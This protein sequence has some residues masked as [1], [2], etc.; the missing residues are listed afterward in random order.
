MI[1]LMPQS[2]WAAWSVQPRRR[3]RWVRG[4]DQGVAVLG[5]CEGDWD[6]RSMGLVEVEDRDSRDCWSVMD[7][8]SVEIFLCVNVVCEG[9]D[10]KEE[11]S[12]V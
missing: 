7:S 3:A 2:C 1:V 12:R 11:E 4:E 8:K 9:K 6:G 5:D 10:N